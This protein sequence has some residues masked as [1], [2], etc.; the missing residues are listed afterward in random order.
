MK[1]K[2]D[3]A[4]NSTAKRST[5]DGFVVKFVSPIGPAFHWFLGLTNKAGMKLPS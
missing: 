1:I 3:R 4:E 5:D 2:S